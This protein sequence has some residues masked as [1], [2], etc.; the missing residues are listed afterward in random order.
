MRTVPETLKP[1]FAVATP[2]EDIQ[3]GRLSEPVFAANLWA[4]VQGTVP[5]V[6]TD[7]DAFFTKTYLIGGLSRVITPGFLPRMAGRFVIG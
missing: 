4:V 1:W 6:Y 2:H 3:K 7:P 5:K